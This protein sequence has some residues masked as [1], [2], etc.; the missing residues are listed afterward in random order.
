MK[1]GKIEEVTISSK[2]LGEDIQILNSL[3]LQ[4]YATL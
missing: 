1:Q 2:E 3:S 4:L